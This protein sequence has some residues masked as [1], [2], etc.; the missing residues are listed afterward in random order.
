MKNHL[1]I[2]FVLIHC[3]FFAQIKPLKT[4]TKKEN[5]VVAPVNIPKTSQAS[6]DGD[7]YSV[8]SQQLIE[9]TRRQEFQKNET[10]AT[11]NY[12]E[13]LIADL[14]QSKV[15]T[16]LLAFNQYLA[17]GRTNAKFKLLNDAYLQSPTNINIVSEMIAYYV[18]TNQQAEVK[19]YLKK[20][21]NIDA[22]N[23]HLS[24]YFKDIFVLAP[25]NAT[26]LFH[27]FEDSYNALYVQQ[28]LGVRPDIRIVN[29]DWLTVND[30]R[31]F[32]QQQGFTLPET[33]TVNSTFVRQLISMN[34][35]IQWGV[36][37]TLPKAYLEQ[38]PSDAQLCGTV[39]WLNTAIRNFSWHTFTFIQMQPGNTQAKKW[40]KNYLLYLNQ[41]RLE[42]NLKQQQAIDIK[43]KMLQIAQW[44][45]I[46]P[47]IKAILNSN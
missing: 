47:Q 15:N 24:A 13:K 42:F 44:N 36:S 32:L 6:F 1:L 16:A 4:P 25:K 5:S 10:N 39:Y 29:L 34:P 40:T 46:E 17:S 30:Y 22:L 27:G 38:L 28:I 3:C 23:I 8:Q 21:M 41:L 2:F 45:A 18:R 9:Q 37:L 7:S 20:L 43:N 33:Q 14:E 31:K 35:Q 26:L 11:K 12:R 19:E